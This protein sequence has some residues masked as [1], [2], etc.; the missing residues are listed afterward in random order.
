MYLSYMYGIIEE[1]PFKPPQTLRD[2][3]HPLN[4]PEY[5]H[6]QH[7]PM[8][9]FEIYSVKGFSA[10]ADTRH[11]LLLSLGPRRPS[12][13]SRL[14]STS[15]VRPRRSSRASPSSLIPKRRTRDIE[16]LRFPLFKIENHIRSFIDAR[17]GYTGWKILFYMLAMKSVLS[18]FVR[19]MKSLQYCPQYQ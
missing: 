9:N 3:P 11:H 18:L 1:D 12:P 4:S 6:C 8:T 15:S 7:D 17:Y 14:S 19:E 13:W 10:E 16:S 5:V 2:Q